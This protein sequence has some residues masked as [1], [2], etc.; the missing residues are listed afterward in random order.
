M[1]DHFEYLVDT[2]KKLMLGASAYSEKDM[3]DDF[4]K[5]GLEG[6]ELVTMGGATM[7]GNILHIQFIWKRKIEETQQ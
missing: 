3:E 7:I 1:A 2:K 5:R 6:W 4:N